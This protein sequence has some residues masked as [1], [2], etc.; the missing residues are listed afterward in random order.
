MSSIMRRAIEQGP[1]LDGQDIYVLKIWLLEITAAA[2]TYG[3]FLCIGL[4]TTYTVIRRGLRKQR[5]R[6]ALLAIILIMLV[7]ATA[8]LALYMAWM[9][10]Q[11]PS[12]AAEYVDRTM[13]LNRLGL[14]Q[15]WIRRLTYFL[16]DIIVVW[17]AWVIWPNNR[18]VHAGLFVCLL[19]TGATSLTL[20]VFNYNTQFR[21]KHYHAL[22]QNFL[23]TF[24]LLITNFASTALISYKLWYYRQNIKKHLN[25]AGGSKTKVESV[26]ILLMESG[27]LYLAFWILLMVGDFGYYGPDFGFEW[28]QPNISGLYPTVIILMVSRQMMMSEDLITDGPNLCTSNPSTERTIWFASPSAYSTRRSQSR[29]VVRISDVS[30]AGL[31]PVAL[32]SPGKE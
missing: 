21:H 8:H 27:G 7:G 2:V 10:V 20:A 14:A 1:G 5:P 17:R 9:I 23:G 24:P 32:A 29:S 15:T 6:Q 13:L 22:E 28:F 31:H 25:R 19:A 26:L 3:L 11:L 16:S 12:L 18:I 4:M 30:A